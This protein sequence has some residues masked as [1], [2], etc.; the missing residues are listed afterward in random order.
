MLEGQQESPQKML[1]F[2]K[3]PLP[4]NWVGAMQVVVA[5]SGRQGGFEVLESTQHLASRGTN[6]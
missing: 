2:G 1:G 6:W 3:D 4:W 5:E